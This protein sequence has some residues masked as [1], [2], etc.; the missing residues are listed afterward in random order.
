MKLNIGSGNM[1]PNCVFAKD[2]TNV[3][4]NYDGTKPEWKNGMYLNFDITKHWP[5][6]HDSVDCIFASHIFEHIELKDLGYTLIQCY[7]VLKP[8][9][10]IRIICPDPR[11]FI[12]QWKMNNKEFLIDVFGKE[13]CVNWEYE[14]FPHE[15]FTTMFFGDRIAHALISSIDTIQILLIRLGF[16]KVEELNC[17]VTMFP[18]YF[19][20]PEDK[21]FGITSFDNRPSMSWYLEAIK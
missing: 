5:L 17:G 6:Q 12:K 9:A 13:N 1:D 7:R 15:V 4:I 19:R 14:R 2:W 8:G 16:S 18:Q 20:I 3:D 10:P 21:A 11:I